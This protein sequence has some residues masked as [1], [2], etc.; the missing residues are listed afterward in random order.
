MTI[1]IPQ[2]GLKAYALLFSKHGVHVRFRQSALDWIVSIS[3]KKKIFALLLRTGWI[4]KKS[5]GTY[6]CTNPSDAIKGLL[7]F[8][9]PTI[10]TKA[11]KNYAFTQLSAV[12]IWSDFSYVQRSMEK[13]PYFIRVLQ[14]DLKYWKKFFNNNEIPNY[15]HSGTTIGEYVILIPTHSLSF[16]ETTGFKVDSLKKTIHYAKSNEIYA[17]AS[18][19]IEHKYGT[20]A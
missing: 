1:E 11:T 9:V 5:D 14:K 4:Q 20:P 19:Y 15:V 13:S 6:V 10:I 2:Y 17:Y 16:E 18:K 12:E 3:M 7:E 8:R